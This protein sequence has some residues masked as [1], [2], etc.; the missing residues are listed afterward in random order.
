MEIKQKKIFSLR[1][2][3][4][5]CL[6]AFLIATI[7]PY[8][9][10][11]IQSYGLSADFMAAGAILGLFVLVLFLNPLFSLI[12]K[13]LV[14]SSSE[15]L[16][17]YMM[18]L[19]A[20]AIPTWGLM[21]NLIPIISGVT[22]YATPEN[23]WAELILPHIKSWLIPQNKEAVT[24]FYEGLPK[25][26]PIPYSAWLIPL[27]TWFSFI[28]VVYFVNRKTFLPSIFYSPINKFAN[29][30]TPFFTDSNSSTTIMII[31]WVFSICASIY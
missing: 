10:M 16:L 4:T 11:M 27:L 22:Y 21:T 5:G 1:A 18:M 7:C 6:L 15:L 2:F 13:N 30:F 12:H 31:A 8:T 29:I 25:G 17:I 9:I 24:Y 26:M 20:S 14:F 23:R 19:I 28:I 3:L